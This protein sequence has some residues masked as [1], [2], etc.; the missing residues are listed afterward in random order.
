MNEFLPEGYKV[1]KAPSN[2]MKFE[3]GKNKFRVAGSAIIGYVYWT[4]DNKPSRVKTQPVGV[5]V[6]IKLND[7][8]TPQKINHFWAFP[9]LV[10]TNIE[11]EET[12][13][14][15]EA[16]VIKILEITQKTVQSEIQDL[17]ANEDWGTPQGYDI[18][19]N[20]KG[21]KLTTEYTVQ[22]SPHK[23]LT[24]SQ[25]KAIEMTKINLNA[26]FDNG[27]P[28]DGMNP[29]PQFAVEPAPQTNEKDHIG[30]G[31]PEEV[32]ESYGATSYEETA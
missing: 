27:D 16:D 10:K 14:M 30:E 19:V 22:P 23:E 28:F 12:G 25:K 9:V 31:M 8:G 11:N 6:G 26:L 15:E 3:K 1:P 29:E 20:R 18:T 4:T 13:E 32:V 5:P 7:D 24:E 17:I 21:D 2:Y